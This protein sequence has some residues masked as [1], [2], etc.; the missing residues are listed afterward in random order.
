[1]LLLHIGF[2][3]FGLLRD[4]NQLYTFTFEMLI[5]MELLDVL[6]IRDRKHFWNSQPSKFLLLAIAGD[7]TL[8]L[9][10]IN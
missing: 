6:I 8:V 9:S 10:C 7:L 2:S 5:F 4:I 3:Y 1:M